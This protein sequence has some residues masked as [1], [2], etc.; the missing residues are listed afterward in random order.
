MRAIAWLPPGLFAPCGRLRDMGPHGGHLAPARRHLASARRGEEA[1][2]RRPPGEKPE[3]PP[4]QL[5]R[6]G[7]AQ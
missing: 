6:E 5:A 1:A 7:R 2:T 3:H 4:K